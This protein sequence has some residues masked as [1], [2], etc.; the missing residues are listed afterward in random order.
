MQCSFIWW[1]KSAAEIHKKIKQ[2]SGFLFFIYLSNF[3]LCLSMIG[4]IRFPAER[5]FTVERGRWTCSFLML[6]AVKYAFYFHVAPKNHLVYH[7]R[8]SWKTFST[9][10]LCLSTSF[11]MEAVNRPSILICYFLYFFFRFQIFFF[12]F[13]VLFCSILSSS[14]FFFFCCVIFHF[15]NIVIY[16]FILFYLFFPLLFCSVRF[17]LFF[18]A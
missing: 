5:L 8:S 6:S 9:K 15:L 14:S 1:R 18:T 16:L 12:C 11:P 3:F 13:S 17:F 10:C 2:I 4:M 7:I